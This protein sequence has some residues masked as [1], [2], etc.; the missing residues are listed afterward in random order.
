MSIL[1]LIEKKYDIEDVSKEEYNEIS[2]T[3][4]VDFGG[5]EWVES[6][7]DFVELMERVESGKEFL[8]YERIVRYKN[9]YSL[10]YD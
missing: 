5:I 1:T 4:G 3:Y 7:V 10:I 9:K 8:C 2:K 6:H